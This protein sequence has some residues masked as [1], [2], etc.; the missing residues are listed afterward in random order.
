MEQLETE[1]QKQLDR[2]RHGTDALTA[3]MTVREVLEI[4]RNEQ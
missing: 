3:S 1:A 2:E 4:E